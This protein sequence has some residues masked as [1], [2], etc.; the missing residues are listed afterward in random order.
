MDKYEIA[1]Q[2]TLAMVDKGF[3]AASGSSQ[4]ER[5]ASTA[6]FFNAVLGNLKL[7]STC[8]PQEQEVK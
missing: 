3:C 5:G 4:E 7:T 6:A 1:L 2:L 8:N